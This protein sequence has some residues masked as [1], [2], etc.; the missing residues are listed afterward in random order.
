[1]SHRGGLAL[2]VACNGC[3]DLEW[4]DFALQIVVGL[5]AAGLLLLVGLGFLF[6]RA[7]CGGSSRPKV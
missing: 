3:T 4:I 5:S 7:C 6:S 1:M 2:P